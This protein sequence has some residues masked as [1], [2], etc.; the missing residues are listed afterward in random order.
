MRVDEVLH[1]LLNSGA[2][3]MNNTAQRACEA[4]KSDK[5]HA[6]E[7]DDRMQQLRNTSSQLGFYPGVEEFD[8]TSV[9]TRVLSLRSL[10]KR[11][12]QQ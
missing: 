1:V 5:H 2:R 8:N 10:I 4:D 7:L 3:R 12:C 9:S 11:Y 6:E